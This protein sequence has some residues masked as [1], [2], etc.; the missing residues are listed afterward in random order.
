MFGVISSAWALLL[1]IGLMMLGNGLQGT[2]LGVRASIEGFPTTVTGL[3]MSGYFVGFFAG[4]V[5]APRIVKQVGHIRVFAALASIA[6]S[7]VL[8]HSIYVEPFTWFAMRLATGFAYAGLYVVAESW[9]N[10]RATNET[11]GQLLS[12]YMVVVFAGLAGGQLLL[13]V[14]DPS[15]FE[16][17]VLVSV[18]VSFSLVPISLTATSAPD[19]SAP[20]AVGIKTLYHTS[21]LGVMG[22]IGTGAAHGAI[23][24]MGAVYARNVGFSVAQ[25]SIFMGI[26]VVGGLLLQWPI[27][28]L[29]DRLDRRKVLTGVS[30]LA[31]LVALTAY[32]MSEATVVGMFAVVFLFGGLSL[33]MYS[34]CIAHTND[35]L[36]P[37]QV[38]AASAGL[39]LVSGVGLVMGPVFGSMLMSIAGDN[40]LFLFLGSVHLLVG[41]FAIYRMTR[42]ESVGVEVQRRFRA[43][44]TRSSTVAT[45]LATQRIRDQQDRELAR[46]SPR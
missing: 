37:H 36:Q 38:I 41:M 43:M 19:F 25:I 2:L 9:L 3:V 29:S 17:F 35:H 32:P 18:L 1:G 10:D 30:I 11:R 15:G 31:G 6:S 23:F 40:G 46:V 44:P 16:L 42:R 28:R 14:S 8:L 34:L 20:S 27:G 4:S 13:N 5:I 39:V 7:A 26:M 24:S 45:A 12:I 21:P 22:A 33:P